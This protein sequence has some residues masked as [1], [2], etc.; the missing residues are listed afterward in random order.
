LID[1]GL[2]A[3]LDFEFFWIFQDVWMLAF[4]ELGSWFFFGF[5]FIQLGLSSDNLDFLNPRINHT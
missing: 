1:L 5:S 3:F 4:L 2:R